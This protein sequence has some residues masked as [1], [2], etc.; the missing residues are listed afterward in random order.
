MELR[1]KTENEIV[2]LLLKDGSIIKELEAFGYTRDRVLADNRF[3][4]EAI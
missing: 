2:E 1:E 3:D 4:R